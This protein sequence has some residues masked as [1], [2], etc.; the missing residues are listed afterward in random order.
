MC[1][2]DSSQGEDLDAETDPADPAGIADPKVRQWWGCA[3]SF[4]WMGLV[5]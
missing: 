5:I 2:Q 1:S 4:L 3:L